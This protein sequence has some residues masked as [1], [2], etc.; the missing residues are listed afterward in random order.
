MLALA[1]LATPSNA[2]SRPRPRRGGALTDT[3][4]RTDFSIKLET[5]APTLAL[6]ASAS[7]KP[8]KAAELL[9]HQ[10]VLGGG[11]ALFGARP[12]VATFHPTFS[13][14][15]NLSKFSGA[16][17]R[18]AAPTTLKPI[19]AAADAEL[20]SFGEAAGA[21]KNGDVSLADSTV[22]SIGV[23]CGGGAA[24]VWCAEPLPLAEL[25]VSED[26]IEASGSTSSE[27]S[28]KTATAHSKSEA[29]ETGTK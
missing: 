16:A 19:G 13:I 9:L 21:V 6:A 26:P 25:C 2:A 15:F 23:T 17:S 28:L 29:D 10:D 3:R 22:N 27:T 8:N 14:P 4:N 12:D 18:A 11:G 1:L 20:A 7:R 5:D 24:P